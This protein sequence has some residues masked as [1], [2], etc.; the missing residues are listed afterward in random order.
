[1]K[2]NLEIEK[3]YILKND[4]SYENLLEYL[5]NNNCQILVKKVIVGNDYFFDDNKF[6]L[7]NQKGYLKISNF[8]IDNK[9]KKSEVVLKFGDGQDNFRRKEILLESN[10]GSFIDFNTD[11]SYDKF[12]LIINTYLK[13]KIKN[14]YNFSSI[15]FKR[16]KYIIQYFNLKIEMPFDDRIYFNN[17]NKTSIKERIMEIELIN[18]KEENVQEFIDLTNCIN[19][20]FKNSLLFTKDSKLDRLIKLLKINSNPV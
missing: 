2:E 10:N 13:K 7:Y 11:E 20:D 16:V 8:I 1:L 5:Q 19:N 6:T 15:N 9:L 18:N 4:I 12:L 3:R 14:L 17:L